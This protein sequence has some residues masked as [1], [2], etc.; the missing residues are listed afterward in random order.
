MLNVD[1]ILLLGRPAHT[2][3]ELL[4]QHEIQVE[5]SKYNM[6]LTFD[7]CIDLTINRTRSSVRFL[8]FGASGIS[9]SLFERLGRQQ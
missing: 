2:I 4:H 8:E 9:R 1:D 5:Y 3:N 7:N 6:K